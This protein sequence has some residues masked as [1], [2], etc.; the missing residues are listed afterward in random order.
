M[1]Y[2]IGNNFGWT[3]PPQNDFSLSNSMSMWGSSPV[4]PAAS[5]VSPDMAA[6]LDFEQ[7]KLAAAQP[8]GWQSGMQ[9]FG[10]VANGLANLAGA[11]TAWQNMKLQKDAFKFNK[12]VTN[13]NLNNSIMDYNRR[14]GDILANRALNNGQG[15][16]WISEQLAKYSAKR[17]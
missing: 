13:T 15:Q 8:T 14:L 7:Q 12:G 2:Q 16:G 5:S 1:S 6:F 9:T 10:S 11:Y 3:T 4:Q 17:S